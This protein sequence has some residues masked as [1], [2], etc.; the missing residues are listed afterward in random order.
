[1]TEEGEVK[2]SSVSAFDG[3]ERWRSEG[4]QIGGVQSARGVVGTWFDRYGYRKC[5]FFQ[6]IGARR[7]FLTLLA[8]L[9]VT[10]TYTGQ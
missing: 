3:Q 1:M 8:T 2:W 6:F 10:T 5:F 4:V 9:L 7:L